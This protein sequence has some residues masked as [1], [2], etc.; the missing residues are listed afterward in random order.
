MGMAGKYPSGYEC[1]MMGGGGQDHATGSA[2]SAYVYSNWPENVQIIFSGFEVGVE[3][4]TGG[5]IYD[6]VPDT[7]PIKTA[8]ADYVGY[9]NTRNSWDP[10][11][12]LVAVRG[13][14]A[15]ACSFCSNCEGR[16]AVDGTS[17]NNSWISGP[18]SNQTY[19]V[20]NDA[21]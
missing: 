19:L 15:A 13:P 12:T 9:G 2:A 5:P 20:L 6:C 8:F 14:E 17:G 7:N 4:H 21:Q 10:L 16:V 3:V 11:T 1:N 18:A